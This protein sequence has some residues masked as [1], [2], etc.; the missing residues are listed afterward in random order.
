MLLR[1][2][3]GETEAATAGLAARASAQPSRRRPTGHASRRS[4]IGPAPGA[5]AR[6]DSAGTTARRSS[7]SSPTR[8]T[9]VGDLER[10]AETA[11]AALELA[12]AND[13][14][15]TAARARVVKLRMTMD[16]STGE[17]DQVSLNAAAKP[18]LD[19]LEALG[20]DEGLAAVL[21]HLGQSTRTATSRSSAYLERAMV[22]AERAGDRRRAACAA[23]FLGSITVFGPV[24]AAEGIERCRALR[25]QF[26]DQPGTSAAPAPSRSGAA[27]D[28]GP[29]RRG[30]RAARRSRTRISMTS[31]AR[32]C[33]ASTVFGHWVLELLAGAPERAEAVGPHE[34]RAPAGD[35]RHQPG[36]DRRRDAGLRARRAGPPRRG[37]PLRRPRRGVGRA[38]RHRLAGS[39]ARRPRARPRGAR[40]TRARRGGRARSGATLRALRRICPQGDALTDLAAVLERAGRPDEAAAA[41]LRDAIALYKRKGNIVSAAR[42]HTALQPSDTGRTSRTRSQSP[43]LPAFPRS[44]PPRTDVRNDYSYLTEGSGRRTASTRS[45]YRVGRGAAVRQTPRARSE[46]RRGA[47]ARREALVAQG[48]SSAAIAERLVLDGPPAS[49]TFPGQRPVRRAAGPMAGQHDHD[50]AIARLH[51]DGLADEAVRN[52]VARRAEPDRRQPVDLA[53]VAAGNDQPAGRQ[54][55]QQR[56]LDGKGAPSAAPGSRSGPGVDL[57]TPRRPA[58]LA[59][60]KEPNPS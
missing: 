5:G 53:L 45:Y 49:T 36:L 37:A 56:Q 2:E 10:C 54:R 59:S 57:L 25:R 52:R 28:A 40:R 51:R 24:P 12:C 55:P 31:A 27:R 26:A 17:A 14:R 42:A 6:A 13:D 60:S 18:V 34:P 41:A 35:G 7:S 38:R 22:A 15:R 32:G 29:H 4:R 58:W 33:R 50:I 16:R 8:S 21:L 43:P 3:L 1:R 47:C 46:Q 44:L 48:N 30:A 23:G 19:E 9:S 20:D 11:A 39:A